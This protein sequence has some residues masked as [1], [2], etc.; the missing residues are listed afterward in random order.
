[1]A[2]SEAKFVKHV[3]GKTSRWSFESIEDFDPRPVEYRGTAS[4]N[5]PDLLEKIRGEL[6][7]ISLL[8]DPSFCHD[9]E[10]SSSETTQLAPVLPNVSNL[11]ETI[12][13]FKT[14]LSMTEDEIREIEQSTREQRNSTKWFLHSLVQFY[15][16]NL[17]HH[18]M[19]WL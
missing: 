2:I 1:M 15:I 18:Q 19:H 16:E 4:L 9:Y 12:L 14:S 17:V 10:T 3:Y 8:L 13:A 6:L 5:L 11:K 7:C